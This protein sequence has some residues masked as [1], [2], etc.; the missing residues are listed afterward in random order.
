MVQEQLL[1]VH[2]N[3]L[4]KRVTDS[5]AVEPPPS[6]FPTRSPTG[7]SGKEQCRAGDPSACRSDNGRGCRKFSKFSHRFPPLLQKLLRGSRIEE[8]GIRPLPLEER[9][10]Q[11]FFSIFT[12]W[13]SINSNILAY[14]TTHQL[15]PSN[16]A[17]TGLRML[18][19]TPTS[20]LCSITFGMLGPLAYNLS[21]RD[22]ALV[23]LFFNLLASVA[24]AFLAT[25][26]PK[27]GMRQM[28]H[29][30]YSFGYDIGSLLLVLF[31]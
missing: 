16:T 30:R 22:S 1:D 20:A 11:R 26:G 14:V 12:I 2:D 19:V 17:L 13:F 31:R 25:F 28:I 27:T 6:H 15:L 23:I 8:N 18:I 10:E 21:L 3:S 4:T 7:A 29:A 9:K 24:P 5:Q